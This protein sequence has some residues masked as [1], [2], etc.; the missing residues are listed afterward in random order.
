MTG[1]LNMGGQSVYNAQDI[2]A[3][4]TTTTGILEN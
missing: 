4:G 3:A 2:T 1:N